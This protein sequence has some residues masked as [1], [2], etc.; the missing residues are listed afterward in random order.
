MTTIETII[1][2]I[3]RE[4]N[5]S[6]ETEREVLDEIRTHFEDAVEDGKQQG[7][8]DASALALA[9]SHFGV[10]ATSDALKEVHLQWESADAVIACM[11]PTMAALV[12]RWISFAPNGSAIGWQSALLKPAFWVVAIVCLL[13][14]MLQFNQWRYAMVSWCIFWFFTVIFITLPNIQSW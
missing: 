9:A 2:Q 12:L 13:V 11:V 14:P 10:T 5:L 8:D 1:D 6:Q 7:L 4:L 3:G